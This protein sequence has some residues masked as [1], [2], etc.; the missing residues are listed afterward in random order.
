MCPHG[1]KTA[2]R[3]L[4]RQTAQSVVVQP[5]VS[6]SGGP[7]LRR[8]AFASSTAFFKAAESPNLQPNAR[9]TS[10]Q[11]RTNLL[12]SSGGARNATRP[13]ASAGRA[14]AS[15][16]TEQN[17]PEIGRTARG[18]PEPQGRARRQRT[19]RCPSITVHVRQEPGST[20]FICKR[21]SGRQALGWWRDDWFTTI[22][23]QL[24]IKE[25]VRIVDFEDVRKHILV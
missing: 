9:S 22:R 11:R 13:S 19:S 24:E 16:H 1:A 14:R 15:G 10:T 17:T 23:S 4:T 3:L 12:L 20:Y 8:A 5:S 7:H 18:R 21:C 2:S 6:I 25:H